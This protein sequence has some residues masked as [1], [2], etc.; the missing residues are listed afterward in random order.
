MEWITKLPISLQNYIHQQDDAKRS[1]RTSH[2]ANLGG[3]KTKFLDVDAK[4]EDFDVEIRD[5]NVE[6]FRV[7]EIPI[8]FDDV[9]LRVQSRHCGRYRVHIF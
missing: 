4:F 1:D 8:H 2:G 9:V 7:Y 3:W 5:V 6:C